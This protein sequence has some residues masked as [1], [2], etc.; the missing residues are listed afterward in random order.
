MSRPALSQTPI[1]SFSGRDCRTR[2][3]T[4]HSFDRLSEQE[5]VVLGKEDNLRISK[6]FADTGV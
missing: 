1:R 2:E 5:V 3:R 4:D 6:M